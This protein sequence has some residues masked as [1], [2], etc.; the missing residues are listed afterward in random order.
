MI[1]TGESMASFSK[2]ADWTLLALLAP[3]AQV[4]AARELALTSCSPS[5]SPSKVSTTSVDGHQVRFRREVFPCTDE[6]TY[7][8]EHQ[9]Q[10]RGLA[11]PNL[12]PRDE[13]G[14]AA[15]RR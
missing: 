7:D 9:I 11:V 14:R 4:A 5:R 3:C 2:S 8:K 6:T 15:R 1:A 10:F 12:M 13:H